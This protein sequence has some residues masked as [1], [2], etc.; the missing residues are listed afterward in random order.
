MKLQIDSKSLILK[1]AVGVGRNICASRGGETWKYSPY[2][3]VQ[4]KDFMLL[5]PNLDGRSRRR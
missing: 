5:Y 2:L 1:D 4:E 3:D